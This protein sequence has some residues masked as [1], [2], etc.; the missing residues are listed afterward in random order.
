MTDIATEVAAIIESFAAEQRAT[1]I[2]D[3]QR[4]KMTLARKLADD[5]Q[6]VFEAVV[7]RTTDRAELDA[8]LDRIAAAGDR[9]E[10]MIALGAH[11]IQLRL[12]QGLLERRKK[13]L[14]FHVAKFKAE[15]EVR[16]SKRHSVL[17]GGEELR[18]IDQANLNQISTG[19][20]EA[21]AQIQE[22]IWTIDECRRIIAGQS[23]LEAIET[24]MRLRE[25]AGE[26]KR[27]A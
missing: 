27:A 24:T 7:D 17:P 19:I 18:S 8:T 10:A 26:A 25:K 4:Q 3:Q 6:L 22:R 21:Q 1:A 14:A 12:D 9:Q 11:L 5:T 16:R 2:A 23:R 20:E 15:A 13:D